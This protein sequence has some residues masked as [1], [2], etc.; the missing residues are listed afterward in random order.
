[1]VEIIGRQ[2]FRDG[3]P[4]ATGTVVTA[5]LIEARHKLARINL[6]NELDRFVTNTLHYAE[7]RNT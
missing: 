7:R 3:E 6:P 4:I 1:M 5:Y 2:V